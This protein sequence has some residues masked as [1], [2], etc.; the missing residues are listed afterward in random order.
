MALHEH[1][2]NNAH[3]VTYTSAASAVTVWGLHANEIAVMVSTLAAVCGAAI[4]VVSYLD[5]RREDR[6]G[7]ETDHGE[8][9]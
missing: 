5:R 6:R 8:T 4:Q 9:H 7:P 1:I 2:S 3:Y